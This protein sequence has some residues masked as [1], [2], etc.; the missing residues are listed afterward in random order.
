[1]SFDIDD[2]EEHESPMQYEEVE[3]C[4]CGTKLDEDGDCNNP[5]CEEDS[6]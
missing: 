1:M 5:Y 3:R 4:K 6:E 2:F